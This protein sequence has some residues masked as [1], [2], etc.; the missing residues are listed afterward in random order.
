MELE[1][2]ESRD[3]SMWK[4]TIPHVIMETKQVC[5]L[6]S[7]KVEIYG[8][9]ELI[10]ESYFVIGLSERYKEMFNFARFNGP[11]KKNPWNAICCKTGLNVGGKT[12][13]IAIQLVLQ[14]C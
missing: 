11:R 3:L 6:Y 13:N 1:E 10:T 14:Q 9:F 7:E 12:G 2:K 4:I 5:C 8:T